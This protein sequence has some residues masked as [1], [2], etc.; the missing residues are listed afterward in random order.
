MTSCSCWQGVVPA[1]YSEEDAQGW[2][3]ASDEPDAVFWCEAAHAVGGNGDAN[4]EAD[5]A[6]A[7][8]EEGEKGERG[9]EIKEIKDLYLRTVTQNKP[10]PIPAKPP[11][12]GRR[13]GAAPARLWGLRRT[14]RTEAEAEAVVAGAEVE[15][16]AG[17]E[18]R[19]AEA[20]GG[21]AGAAEAG[22]E[23]NAD[24][25]GGEDLSAEEEEEE[26]NP[27]LDKEKIELRA[28]QK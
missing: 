2:Y 27:I 23:R 5:E 10:L 13:V 20:G 7:E 19:A 28:I 26:L 3:L 4:D 15:A 1:G 8:D 18:A 6:D 17:A 25:F 12:A 14:Q 9:T 24:G 16:E 11:A 21:A 22:N